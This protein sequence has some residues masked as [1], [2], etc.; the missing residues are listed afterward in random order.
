MPELTPDVD[1]EETKETDELRRE[2]HQEIKSER[3][4]SLSSD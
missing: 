3:E 1:D 4:E 2:I